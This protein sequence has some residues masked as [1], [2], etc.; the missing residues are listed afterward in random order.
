MMVYVCSLEGRHCLNGD[1]TSLDHVDF[2]VAAGAVSKLLN[3]SCWSW[4]GSEVPGLIRKTCLVNINVSFLHL[5]S[6]V[7]ELELN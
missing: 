2:L 6:L 7:E 1:N 5:K 3:C 4:R